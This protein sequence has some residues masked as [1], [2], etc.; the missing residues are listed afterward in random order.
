MDAFMGTCA[1][2]A[3]AVTLT[4]VTTPGSAIG[5]EEMRQ[6]TTIVVNTGAATPSAAPLGYW[7]AGVRYKVEISPAT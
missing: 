3:N 5:G 6:I 2:G 7:Q 4:A 1:I